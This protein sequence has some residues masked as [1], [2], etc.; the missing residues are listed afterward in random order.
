MN[1]YAYVET[2]SNRDSPHTMENSVV[3]GRDKGPSPLE[4]YVPMWLSWLPPLSCNIVMVLGA[5]KWE[6]GKNNQPSHQRRGCLPLCRG[7]L[8]NASDQK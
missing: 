2:K 7:F 6:H 8:S 1:D 3:L 5:R 4:F